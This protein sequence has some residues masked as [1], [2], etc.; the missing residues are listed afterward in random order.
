M[1]KRILLNLKDKENKI[2]EEITKALNP[3]KDT[4]R[5]SNEFIVEGTLEKPI[6]SIKYPA[7]KMVKLEP[8]RKNSAE[9]GN[10]F[11]FVVIIYKDGEGEISGF[12]F[13]K[14][15]H[16][17]E[18]HKKHSEEFWKAIKEVYYKNKV[19]DKLPNLK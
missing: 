14:I 11:D 1:S 9:Y 10:L 13:E 15:L 3:Y 5:F 19:P 6:I 7:K 12:T 2:Y 4:E 16:D 18:E 8:K 17:F